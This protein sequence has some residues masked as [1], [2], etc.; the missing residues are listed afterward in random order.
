MA[1]PPSNGQGQLMA[2]P[3]F[4]GP[5]AAHFPMLQAT[6]TRWDGSQT[7]GEPYGSEEG[8]RA[9]DA[10]MQMIGEAFRRPTEDGR[11]RALGE[12]VRRFPQEALRNPDVYGFLEH[13]SRRRN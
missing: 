4:T 5:E 7:T 13:L 9:G 6:V 2:K 12:C 3:L 1:S 10:A 11:V 8:R